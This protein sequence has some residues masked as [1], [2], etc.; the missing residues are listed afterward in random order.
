MRNRRGAVLD[1][2]AVVRRASEGRS[3][4]IAEAKREASQRL[5]EWRRERAERERAVKTAHSDY[6]GAGTN[7]YQQALDKLTT[8]KSR[9]TYADGMVRRYLEESSG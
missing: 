8:A 1:R 6:I 3:P 7:S 9:L 2:G 5:Q 4:T